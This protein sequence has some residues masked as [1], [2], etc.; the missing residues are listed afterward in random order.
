MGEIVKGVKPVV[1]VE[2]YRSRRPLG[3]QQWR[4]RAYAD[5][6]RKLANSGEAYANLGDCQQAVTVLFHGLHKVTADA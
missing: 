5:N 4:W 2:I 1:T 6:G 3:R